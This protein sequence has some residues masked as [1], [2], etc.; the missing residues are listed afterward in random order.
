MGHHISPGLVCPTCRRPPNRWL[1]SNTSDRCPN[2]AC[3]RLHPTLPGTDIRAAV[4]ADLDAFL[5]FDE[6]LRFDL[7][8]DVAAWIDTLHRGGPAWEAAARLGMYADLHYA[9][10]ASTLDQLYE[11]F[12]APLPATIESALDLGCGLGGF[13]SR[14]AG[15]LGCHVTGLDSW[16]LALRFAE[17]AARHRELHVPI[18]GPDAELIASAITIGHRSA[19][20]TI[21]W[22]CGDLHNP[23]FDARSFD[24]VTALNVFDTVN[25]PALALG[26]ASAM[27]RPGGLLVMAQPDSWNAAATPPDRWIPSDSAA[28]EQLL[29]DYG[30]K[31]IDRDD[32]FV[33]TLTRNART[34]FRYVSQA[35]LVRLAS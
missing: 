3:E 26:Q 31:T 33:W 14:L 13:A 1:L 17:A 20:Q 22:V 4:A 21:R 15:G 29:D 27:L 10:T 18:M 11:R 7:P 28:W 12:I 35:R 6:P 5:E 34:Q 23:P 9:Q 30:L 25:D 19:I 16:P 24:L 32:G 8:A 2:P